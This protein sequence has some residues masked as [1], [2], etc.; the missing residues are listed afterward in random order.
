MI[1]LNGFNIGSVT[2][3]T[4]RVISLLGSCGIQLI[5]NLAQTKRSR[6]AKIPFTSFKVNNIFILYCILFTQIGK[7]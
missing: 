2:L 4:I 7:D 5:I 1:S 6:I 3:Y